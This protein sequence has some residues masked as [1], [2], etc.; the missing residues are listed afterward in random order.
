MVTRRGEKSLS[1]EN[2]GEGQAEFRAEPGTRFPAAGAAGRQLG[3]DAD[4]R[5]DL[6]LLGV[7]DDRLQLGE[8]LDHGDDLL[9]D[10]AG[11]HGHLDELVVLEA[12][13]DDRRVHAVGQRQHRQQLRL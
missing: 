10:L 2:L 3:A 5:P 12:V 13:A 6:Q 1:R 11:Q 7:A 9:A 4:H 8:L